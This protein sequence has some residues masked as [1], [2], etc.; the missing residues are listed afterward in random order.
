MERWAVWFLSHTPEL[1]KQGCR[2]GAKTL[3]RNKGG[4]KFG[5]FRGHFN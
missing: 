2:E 1:L 3:R 4:S 5:K